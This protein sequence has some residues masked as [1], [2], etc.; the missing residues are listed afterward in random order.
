MGIYTHP[1]INTSNKLVGLEMGL[2]DTYGPTHI[3]IK[4]GMLSGSDYQIGEQVPIVDDGVYI[5]GEGLVVVKDGKLIATFEEGCLYTK[6]G[7]KLIESVVIREHDHI[8]KAIWEARREEAINEQIPVKV[9]KKA[10]KA[11]K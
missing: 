11:K 9:R 5:S 6:W 10:K 2:Y 8:Q 3:Q 1:A 7:D 4:A